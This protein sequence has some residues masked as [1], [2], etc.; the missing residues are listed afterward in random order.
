MLADILVGIFLKTGQVG[1]EFGITVDF[2]S[3]ICQNRR[4]KNADEHDYR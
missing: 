1:Y 3:G 4:R 2:V